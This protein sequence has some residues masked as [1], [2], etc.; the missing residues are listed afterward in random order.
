MR[1]FSSFVGRGQLNDLIF[2]VIAD[3]DRSLGVRREASD[4]VVVWLDTFNGLY[5]SGRP[6]D[7][8]L[9]TP[10]ISSFC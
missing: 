10:C 5:M 4:A 6:V 9:R 1:V 3:S 7:S 8:R 2:T